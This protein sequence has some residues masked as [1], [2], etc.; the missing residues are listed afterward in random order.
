MRTFF[1]FYVVPCN[2]LMSLR[3]AKRR[4]NLPEGNRIAFGKR[5]CLRSDVAFG[6]MLLSQRCVP[7]ARYV[8]NPLR[9]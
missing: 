2:A 8:Q 3:G 9:H 1:L 6:A 7:L 4:G 5:C